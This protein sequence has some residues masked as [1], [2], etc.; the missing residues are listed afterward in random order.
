MEKQERAKK[1]QTA[2]IVDLE[3]QLKKLEVEDKEDEERVAGLKRTAL[4]DGYE[5]LFD[6]LIEVS[7]KRPK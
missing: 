4:R 5:G 1:D 7:K 2:K 6:S 3:A